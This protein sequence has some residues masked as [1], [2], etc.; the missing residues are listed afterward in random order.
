MYNPTLRGVY[1]ARDPRFVVRA[2]NKAAHN[3]YDAFHRSLDREVANWV[4]DNPEA[5][6]SDFEKYLRDLYKWPDVAAKFPGG[7]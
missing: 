7:L 6:P 3:G 4:R 2:K 1:K 5:G